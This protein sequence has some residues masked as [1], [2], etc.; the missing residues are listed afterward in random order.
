M[1]ILRMKEATNKLASVILSLN[2]GS[3]EMLIVEYVQL[4]REEI[5]DAKYNMAALVDLTWG[6]EIH[7][8]LYLKEEAME[9]ID[10]DD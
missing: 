3:E 9:G 1:F 7:L 4:A 6:R 8:G 5:V 10:V 2:L